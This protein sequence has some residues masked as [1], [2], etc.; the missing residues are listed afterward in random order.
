MSKLTL[1]VW[2]L[3]ASACL[4]FVQIFYLLHW[5]EIEFL[6]EMAEMGL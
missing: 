3:L 1:A 4:L 2:A 6:L 5:E